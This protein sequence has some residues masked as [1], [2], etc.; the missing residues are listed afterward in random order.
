MVARDSKSLDQGI[1][2]RGDEQFDISTYV[3][4]TVFN[5]AAYPRGMPEFLI[6]HI[7]AEASFAQRLDDAGMTIGGVN[8]GPLGDKSKSERQKDADDRALDNFSTAMEL[9]EREQERQQENERQW[10]ATSHTYAGQTLSGEDW[11]KMAEWFHDPTNA[12]AWEDAMMAQ[13]GQ[14]RDEVRRTGGK[15]KRFYDLMDKDAKGTLTG[16]ERTEFDDLQKDKDVRLGVSVQRQ[17]QGLQNNQTP[18]LSEQRDKALDGGQLTSTA[19]RAD[20]FDTD[21]TSKG[22]ASVPPLS[23]KYQAAAVGTTIPPA[24]PPAALP[25]APNTITVSPDNMFG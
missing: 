8:G 9:V 4:T 21:A 17:V 19:A 5:S 24:Q 15:L 12:T 2:L 18:G 13:T 10:L 14:S 20:L 23:P 6:R 16:V 25:V 3:A 22:L 11:R 7:E 1:E